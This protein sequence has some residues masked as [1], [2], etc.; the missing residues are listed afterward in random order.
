MF[1]TIA[2]V[3]FVIWVLCLLIFKITAGAIHIIVAL[4]VIAFIV[5]FVKGKRTPTP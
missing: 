2:L 3:L 4:A 1:L 5:H